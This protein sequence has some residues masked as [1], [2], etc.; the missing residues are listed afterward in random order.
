MYIYKRARLILRERGLWCFVLAYYHKKIDQLWTLSIGQ[1]YQIFVKIFTFQF[2]IGVCEDK[3][4]LKL[5]SGN[6]HGQKRPIAKVIV[7]KSVTFLA[8]FFCW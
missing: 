8:S 5:V 2:F 6:C 7:L 1:F 3:Y 4:R